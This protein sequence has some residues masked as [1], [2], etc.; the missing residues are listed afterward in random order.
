MPKYICT[1]V[2]FLGRDTLSAIQRGSVGME[3]MNSITR[4]M[5]RSTVPPK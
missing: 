4:W 2:Q 1:T 5:A 3:R